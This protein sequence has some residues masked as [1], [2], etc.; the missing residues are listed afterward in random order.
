[1]RSLYRQILQT[2]AVEN[3]Q[4]NVFGRIGKIPDMFGMVTPMGRSEIEYI[5]ARDSFYLATVSESGWPYVQHRGGPAGFLKVVGNKKLCFLD[6]PGN[7]QLFSIGNIESSEKVSLFLMDYV[8]RERLKILGKARVINWG[9]EPEV[10]AEFDFADAEKSTHKV[11]VIDVIAFDWN[12]PKH[13]TPR[14]VQEDIEEALKEY[15]D[16]IQE[17]EALLSEKN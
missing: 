1:M 6:R 8:A 5:R 15:R 17:L 2:P 12:C 7:R 9:E 16:R 11:F 14:Y 10:D 3:A 13:I 4:K